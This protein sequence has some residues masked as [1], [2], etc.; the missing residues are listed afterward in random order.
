MMQRREFLK[1]AALVAAG[2]LTLPELAHAENTPVRS[3]KPLG[4]PEPFSYAGLKSQARLLAMRP[5]AAPPSR[6]PAPIAN[7]TWDQM[8]AI[9]FKDA[10]ALWRNDDRSFRLRFFHLGLYNKVP[11][12]MFEVVDGRAQQLAFDP[13]MFDYDKSGVDP[14]LLPT[15]LGFA[16][17]QVGFRTDWVR[18]IAAFQGASYFRAVDETKQYGASARGLAVNCGMPEPEEFPIFTAFWFERPA[19]KSDRLTVYALMDSPSVSGAYHF[20]IEPGDTQVMHIDSAIYPRKAIERLGIAPLTSMFLCGENDRRVS[21]DFR[22]EIHDSDG[23][24]MLTGSG[25]WIWRPLTNPTGV[26]FNAFSDQN[27][28]G[29]GLLERDRNFD[30][31][32]D[33]GAFYDRRPSIWVEPKSGPTPEGWGRGTVQLVEIPTADETFDNIVAFWNPIEK[34][35]AGQE[36]LYSYYLHWGWKGPENQPLATVRATRTG[37]GGVVGQ[38]RKYYSWRFVVDFA[39]RNLENL[40]SGL[41]I[42]PVITVSRGE[43]EIPSAR[44]LEAI[45]GWR[46]IFD[47]KPNDASVEPIDLRL[48]LRSEG[49]TLTE[50]WNYQWTPPPVAERKF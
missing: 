4:E 17:F 13:A 27:P 22:P 32:Q 23:L 10:H 48:V 11:I 44:P 25:E 9:R 50:T 12:K 41:K 14:Q 15:D 5:Y 8:Q 42:E 18:D 33:D 37:I 34:P 47:I 21:G 40:P 31:F 36:L 1:S 49:K 24:S 30:H 43:I 20:E 28:R 39:G 38:P 19:P 7:L 3:F 2:S 26:R 16:G 29:F 6:L 45:K 35:Q 46:A